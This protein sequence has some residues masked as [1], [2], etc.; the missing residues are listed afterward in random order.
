MRPSLKAQLTPLTKQLHINIPFVEA[1]A[2]RPKYATF[3]KEVISNKRKLGEFELVE[4]NEECLVIVLQKFPPKLKDPRSFTISC[5]IGNF[6]FERALCDLGANI[7]LIKDHSS[8]KGNNKG[9]PCKVDK[10]IFLAY[11]VV[12]GMEEDDEFPIILGQPF[13]NTRGTFI[14]IR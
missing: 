2:Q 10:F 1:I 6:N 8:C 13:L 14:D 4:L 7:N 12:L 9:H 3:L 5:T 11:F